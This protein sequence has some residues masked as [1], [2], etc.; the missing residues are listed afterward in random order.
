MASSLS[1]SAAQT[2]IVY[3]SDIK[4]V[5]P[6]KGIIEA[7][8]IDGNTGNSSSVNN[9]YGASE[10]CIDLASKLVLSENTGMKLVIETNTSFR[11]SRD[12]TRL[13]ANDNGN[14]DRVMCSLQR[15]SFLL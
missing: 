8:M 10:S 1:A 15:A 11:L 12:Q 3:G 9:T 4:K 6:E 13:Y 7:R 14:V 2:L 5:Q